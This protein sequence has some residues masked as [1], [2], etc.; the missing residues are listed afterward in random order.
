MLEDK[1]SFLVGRGARWGSGASRSR[2]EAS[3]LNGKASLTTVRASLPTGTASLPTC[4]ASLPV[5]RATFS[6]GKASLRIRRASPL[7]RQACLFVTSASFAFARAKVRDLQARRL[8]A[9]AAPPGA[10]VG[11]TRITGALSSRPP[12][13]LI[14]KGAISSGGGPS[15][16]QPF[17]DLDPDPTRA[18]SPSDSTFHIR[19]FLE[20]AGRRRVAAGKEV[21]SRAVDR[22]P[23]RAAPANP[24]SSARRSARGPR[25][26]E[27]TWGRPRRGR[28]VP[29]AQTPW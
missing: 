23:P 1:V 22:D 25:R 11:A 7:V 19:P 2:I 29:A 3:L 24:T 20:R 5:D 13:P 8:E 6:S 4:T 26:A 27:D 12:T 21:A 10:G 18:C 15:I 9:I 17:P 14:A 16:C 28:S